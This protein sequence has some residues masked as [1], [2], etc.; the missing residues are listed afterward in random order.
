MGKT[1]VLIYT[2]VSLLLIA[3]TVV[4]TYFIFVATG[5]IDNAKREV[6]FKIDD[7]EVIYDGKPHSASSVSVISET[8]LVEGDYAILQGLNSLTDVGEIES[9]GKVYIYNKDDVDITHRYKFKLKKGKITI[10]KRSI[11]M[12]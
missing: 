2:L 11:S 8:E 3:A 4:S 12:Q 5:L 1:K 6:E 10:S 9:E 7:V